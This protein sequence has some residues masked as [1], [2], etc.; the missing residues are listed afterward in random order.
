MGRG[1]Q[2]S[3]KILAIFQLKFGLFVSCQ[4]KRLSIKLIIN[5]KISLFIL[6]GNLPNNLEEYSLLI[7]AHFPVSAK[8]EQNFSYLIGQH[9][10]LPYKHTLTEEMGAYWSPRRTLKPRQ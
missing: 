2:M 10:C 4:F 1:V 7:G 5:S 9:R 6:I 3:V 8:T